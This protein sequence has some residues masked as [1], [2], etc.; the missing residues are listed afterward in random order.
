MH[1]LHAM[2]QWRDSKKQPQGEL[3]FVLGR[4]SC[5]LECRHR[6]VCKK[7]LT[8]GDKHAVKGHQRRKGALAKGPHSAGP[9]ERIKLSVECTDDLCSL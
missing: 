8:N 1:R 9:Q 5:V 6:P 2:R 3:T 7:K 4:D